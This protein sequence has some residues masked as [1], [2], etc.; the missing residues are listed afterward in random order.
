MDENEGDDDSLLGDGL[1]FAVLVVVV[2]LV[3]CLPVLAVI[4]LVML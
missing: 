1:L 4:A 3:L 2:A